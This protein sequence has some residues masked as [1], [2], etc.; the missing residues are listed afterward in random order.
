MAS[1]LGQD[2]AVRA[3]ATNDGS[4][5]AKDQ[6][7]KGRGEGINHDAL[8]ACD[9]GQFGVRKE[10]SRTQSCAWLVSSQKA[11]PPPREKSKGNK[12]KESGAAARFSRKH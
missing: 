5:P 1:P 6:N 8:D 2:E 11:F 3:V 10:D 4:Q 12:E 7:G 9:G